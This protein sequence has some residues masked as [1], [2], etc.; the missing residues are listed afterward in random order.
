[1]LEYGAEGDTAARNKPAAQAAK[2][3][4]A[5]TDIVELLSKKTKTTSNQPVSPARD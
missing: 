5:T 2:E 4:G 3:C 1:M